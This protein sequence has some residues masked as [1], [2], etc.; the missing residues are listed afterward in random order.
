[1][2][3]TKHQNLARAIKK[4]LQ[5]VE[6]FY[7][8]VEQSLDLI[9]LHFHEPFLIVGRPLM[10]KEA[11]DSMMK[12]YVL[13]IK[14]FG[15]SANVLPNTRW[16][17]AVVTPSFYPTSHILTSEQTEGHWFV[18]WSVKTVWA[19]TTQADLQNRRIE[20][21]IYSPSEVELPSWIEWEEEDPQFS[22]TTQFHLLCDVSQKRAQLKVNLSQSAFKPFKGIVEEWEE[23]NSFQRKKYPQ[24]FTSIAAT[25]FSPEKETSI[26]LAY[27]AILNVQS[28]GRYHNYFELIQ[29]W[30]IR[31]EELMFVHLNW[32]DE[33]RREFLNEWKRNFLGKSPQAS[34]ET[35]G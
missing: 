33:K 23:R 3:L 34:E 4:M 18:P 6:T 16:L 24:D 7:D 17:G 1:M 2:A 25:S 5:S 30:K 13:G 26:T 9:Q 21:L 32:D 12:L 28:S 20:A 35:D 14:F 31:L 8:Q 27:E 15:S 19:E 29:P 11:I 22:I 10:K